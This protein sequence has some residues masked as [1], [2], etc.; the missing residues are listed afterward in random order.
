MGII[1]NWKAKYGIGLIIALMAVACIGKNKLTVGSGRMEGTIS[2]SQYYRML[3]NGT[4]HSLYGNYRNA[5]P[6]FEACIRAYPERAASYYQLSSVYLRQNNLERATFYAREACERD[7]MNDWYKSHLASIYQYTGKLDSAVTLYQEL[8]VNE[9]NDE[10]K[11]N[12]AHLYN[13]L[14]QGA[15]AIKI[16]EDISEENKF[17][18]EVM[19]MKHS[20]YHEMKK[21]DSAIVV[22]EEIVTLFPDDVNNYGVLAEYL[23]EVGRGIYARN[24]YKEILENEPENGLAMLSFSEYYLKDNKI[25]SAFI[26]Y[27]QAF[28]CSD[29]GIN[30]KTSI[31]INFLNMPDFVQNHKEHI[32]ELMQSI[33]IS[34]R[35]FSYYAAMADIH[36]SMQDYEGAKP[37]L[38]STLVYEREN[39]QVWEQTLLIN[40]YLGND[41]EIIRIAGEALKSFR[42]KGAL[43]LIR[44]NSLYNIGSYED[45][46]IDLD[47]ALSKDLESVQQ[48][49]ALYLYAE[50]YKEKE[51]FRKSDSYFEQII[52]TDPDNLLVRNN[53]AYYLSIRGE[54]LDRAAELSRY[55]IEAEPYNSTYLDTYGWILYK[56]GKLNEAKKYIEAAIRYGAYNNGEVLE[57]YGDIMFELGRCEEALEAYR[58][59]IEIDSLN[60]KAE[61]KILKVSEKCK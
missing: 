57:H 26:W 41:T 43:Y 38:D 23:T 3:T 21:Y 22:L 6:M 27:H 58:T 42:E 39:Y 4:K 32:L 60:I 31:I 8:L 28:C 51:D 25:D 36:I 13:K 20:T 7:S 17:S 55:T 1:M 10:M 56:L 50:I 30:E 29:L 59:I 54:E 35:K 2:E 37:W 5:I 49:Q 52:K 34:E 12:L 46:I 11:Y 48:I 16:L 14:G 19:L 15:K 33:K 61:E 45:A 47:T 9:D 40:S 18:R 44:A 24:V 53:Y